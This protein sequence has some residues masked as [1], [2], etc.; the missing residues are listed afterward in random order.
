MEKTRI[1]RSD[2]YT[3][4]DDRDAK[5]TVFNITRET[6]EQ[7][8]SLVK[9]KARS[10]I[11]STASSVHK[12]LVSRNINFAR[13][14]ERAGQWSRYT[15][16][17]A[18][19]ELG[20]TVA[21]GVSSLFD[22]L[23]GWAH[24]TSFNLTD[25][26]NEVSQ[27]FDQTKENTGAPTA[28]VFTGFR[29]I[30]SAL[31]IIFS[32]AHILIDVALLILNKLSAL[33]IGALVHASVFTASLVGK[34]L[35][36]VA[37]GALFVMGKT[38]QKTGK[39]AIFPFAAIIREARAAYKKERFSSAQHQEEAIE[40]KA[41]VK[42]LTLRTSTPSE[43]N[44]AY[45]EIGKLK[46]FVAKGK[47]EADKLN[48][49]VLGS[50]PT[51][52]LKRA[53]T[54]FTETT[55]FVFDK[56]RPSDVD[57]FIANATRV[58]LLEK[59]SR[60]TPNISK[61][62]LEGINLTLDEAQDLVRSMHLQRLVIT[63]QFLNED[64]SE[65]NKDLM[66]GIL[67]T[68]ATSDKELLQ[69]AIRE[70]GG[71]KAQVTV[72][73]NGLAGN[74]T[75]YSD[76]DFDSPISE[77]NLSTLSSII[78]KGNAYYDGAKHI[79]QNRLD[80]EVAVSALSSNRGFRH[81][82]EMQGI[83]SSLESE[84]DRPLIG[85]SHESFDQEQ[86]IAEMYHAYKQENLRSRTSHFAAS[87]A[88][89]PRARLNSDDSDANLMSQATRTTSFDNVVMD[90]MEDVSLPNKST[91]S[92]KTL[93]LR[94]DDDDD[95]IATPDTPIIRASPLSTPLILQ[96]NYNLF[97]PPVFITPNYSPRSSL[98]TKEVISPELLASIYAHSTIEP[99]ETDA[100]TPAKLE[101][102]V[103]LK[104][105]AEIYGNITTVCKRITN[106]STLLDIAEVE[107]AAL[108]LQKACKENPIGKGNRYTPG[109]PVEVAFNEF[110]AVIY[111][112]A[113]FSA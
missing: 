42:T 105:N 112:K 84:Y 81:F 53:A 80:R 92:H 9:N 59:V 27:F 66:N 110:W 15:G 33:L 67:C 45:A 91:P 46:A 43:Q 103:D 109:T 29:L 17:V 104:K 25:F 107:K 97:S 89:S 6:L 19:E 113:K 1:D 39:V 48:A 87:F 65:E 102:L 68:L 12:A 36:F 55:A 69:I 32:S 50:I 11:L 98:E 3:A 75:F 83:D 40:A 5:L 60:Y 10:S 70:D 21:L 72:E 93:V 8:S 34:G 30:A 63:N 49:R 76:E 71:F 61:K 108:A 38:A 18:A 26:T 47:A 54:Y 74:Y 85:H 28:L 100:Q 31:S 22:L 77:K 16:Y 20:R 111:R 24:A 73:D 51:T 101:L 57:A 2:A 96:S 78:V 58:D 88:S 13:S 7:N 79:V 95:I 82:L 64:V 62:D 44:A 37:A 56:K 35:L 23:T 4:P 94:D 106:L 14:P 86:Q 99:Q 52:R 41:W 90:S